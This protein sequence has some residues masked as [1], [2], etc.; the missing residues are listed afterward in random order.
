MALFV[1]PVAHSKLTCKEKSEYGSE[2]A[3]DVET[4]FSLLY[5]LTRD[6]LKGGTTYAED[7]D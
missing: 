4:P 7:I 1:S 6:H 3:S 2:N 5:Q